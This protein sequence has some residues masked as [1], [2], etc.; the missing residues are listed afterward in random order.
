MGYLERCTKTLAIGNDS[1]PSDSYKTI[2]DV[3]ECIIR[4]E[5]SIRREDDLPRKMYKD[6]GYR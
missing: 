1:T 6:L 4:A 2:D 5:Q 3:M